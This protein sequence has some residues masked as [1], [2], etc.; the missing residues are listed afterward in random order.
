MVAAVKREH[1]RAPFD[2]IHAQ[3]GYPTGW[4]ALL[5]AADLGLPSVV[6]IQGGDGHWVG[7][8]CQTHYHAFRRVLD[9]ASALLIGGE[10][11]VAEVSERM[12]VPPTRFT[13]VPGAVDTGRFAPGHR[14][15]R[16]APVPRL[17]YHGR[18]DR[19]KGVLDF[20]EALVL[21]RAQGVAFAATVS[22]IGPDAEP[23]RALAAE[24]GFAPEAVRFTG[25]AD[26]EA[27]PQL[28]AGADI[29]ASPTYAEGFSNTILEAMAAGL[30]VASCDVVGVA[31]CL[32]DGDNGLLTA[33][34]DVPAHAA[35]LRRLIEDEPLRRGVA[36]RALGG[37][38]RGLL[39]GDG[40]RADH[41]DLRRSRR[42][43]HGPRFP[44]RPRADAVPLPSAAAPAVTRPVA[45]ALSPH[46]D[47]AAFSAGGRLAQLA[48]EGWRVVVATVFTASMPDPQGFALACQLDKGLAADI[49]YMALRRAED[50]NACRLLGAE[51]LWLP[52]PEAPH[53]GY[54]DARALFA[55][56]HAGDAIV[57][58][59]VSALAKLVAELDPACIFAPQA[60]GAHVDHVAVV[61]ALRTIGP[62]G[63]QW[64]LDYPYAAR[65]GLIAEPFGPW[66]ADLPEQV[67]DLDAESRAAKSAAALA[68]ASQLGFQFGGEDA[69]RARFASLDRE[70]FRLSP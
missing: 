13:R 62:S 32:R 41:G 35:A 54:G 20:I 67:A 70:T 26:Y 36:E 37:S 44:P 69:A 51:P 6:S 31:D 4:A 61:E 46:L 33:A 1:A 18:V 11:F 9:H 2:V 17:L 63:V 27:A 60:V 34:G 40:G 50:A 10:S 47:D 23:A 49:D 39:L 21:L 53:R 16:V 19:R 57:P 24:R 56:M 22:G 30:P 5:A 28:Y 38:A 42:H 64:W 65:S 15:G 25:Y 68:Y 14:A 66:F 8:C 52:F 12:G 55:G 43:A 7:S 3:Y 29:F 48:R 45:L 58:E 59:V